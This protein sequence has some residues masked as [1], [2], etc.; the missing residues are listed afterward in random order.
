MSDTAFRAWRKKMGVT[1]DDAADLLGV[2][3]SQ[4]AN[5]DSGRD[6][7]S[8]QASRPGFA[9]RTVMALLIRGQQVQAWPE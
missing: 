4:V 1:Q 2:S 9:V 7:S 6:R 3:K 5:W 8:G